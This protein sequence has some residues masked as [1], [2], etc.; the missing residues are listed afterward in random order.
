MLCFDG[1]LLLRRFV[2]RA[3]CRPALSARV[4]AL[5][6]IGAYADVNSVCDFLVN[7]KPLILTAISLCC[8]VT[9]R[10]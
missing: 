6:L 3:A 5:G 2:L 7:A 9:R 4:S 8:V 10:I 1:G